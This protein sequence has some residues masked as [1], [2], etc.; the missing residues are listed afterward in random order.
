MKKIIISVAVILLL[1]L[2][3]IIFKPLFGGFNINEYL[4]Y[5][6][7]N[8]K[9]GSVEIIY[10]QDSTVFPPDIVAPTFRWQADSTIVQKFILL[11]EVDGKVKANS[12]IVTGQHW[13]PDTKL[14]NEIKTFSREKIINV[15]I[16]G[17]SN[18][19]TA[20]PIA[21][22]SVSI[23][24]SK[25]EVG[26]P[27]FF[28]MV[29][30][31]FTFA[32]NN[33]EK[34]QWK[35]G[36]VSWDRAKTTLTNLP[37]CA[38]CHSFS[39]DGK[40]IGMDVDYANDKGS[41]AIAPI[42]NEVELSIDH[43]ISWSDF[44][45]GDGTKTYGLLSQVSPDGKYA[46]S[47]V[48]DRSI[49]VSKNDP[50][51]SQLFFPIKGILTIYDRQSKIFKALPGADNPKY[52][53][54]N[55]SWSPDS[56]YIYFSKTE[57]FTTLEIEK[58][59]K[60][61]LPTSV[62]KDFI[63]GRKRF[64]YDIYKI[65]FNNGNGGEAQPLKGASQNGMSNYFPKISPDGRWL[66]FTQSKDFMLLQPDSKLYI[67]PAE[68][69]T[70][71]LM[72]CNT[73]EM[74]SWHSWSP[75]GRWLVF[76]SK[77]GGA[78]T[79]LYLTHID[80]DGNDSPPVLLDNFSE[81]DLAANIPEFINLQKG[82]SFKIVE[83]FLSS[84]FYA[85]NRSGAKA[86][87][88]DIKGAIADLD[89]AIELK[90]NNIQL[91]IDRAALKRKNANLNGALADL[92]KSIQLAHDKSSAYFERGMVNMDMGNFTKAINDF[93]SVLKLEPEYIMAYYERAVAKYYQNDFHG[94]IEDC[95]KVI[96]LRPDTKYA[97]FQRGLANYRLGQ[98]EVGCFDLNH[99]YQLGCQE[100]WQVLQEYCK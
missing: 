83:R 99:S 76:A 87:T 15:I 16:V 45:R 32:L 68:G 22:E 4:D 37:V 3:Y 20:K 44:K 29:P 40:T 17:V 59:D 36:Y 49:F 80:K 26:A 90:P 74:N 85:E 86:K 41:Y 100:A 5:W 92:D 65:P 88:G 2:L 43:I 94:T 47:T 38:N 77:A 97:Y 64:F 61:I 95:N 70:P 53:Q 8:K 6:K 52:V 98:K 34:I 1:V 39:A 73:N 27:V 79:Q 56:K 35:I 50:Y 62:A 58:S 78:Y 33:T 63:E 60:P 42:K 31:P 96:T 10:P 48:K 54:S 89:K 91:L 67:M 93:S 9:T 30:L 84:D 12:E 82:E 18:D 14:W 69:G 71:R 81:V 66:V 75:N 13:K 57:V 72:R 11:F 46:V 25:D 7:T 51:Y 55:A 21:V 24:T 28:R 19:K 23:L